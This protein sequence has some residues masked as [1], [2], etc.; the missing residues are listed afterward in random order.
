MLNTI[1]NLEKSYIFQ[2]FQPFLSR[3]LI[4]DLRKIRNSNKEI[5][6]KKIIKESKNNSWIIGVIDIGS[7][8]YT[9]G[10]SDIDLIIVVKKNIPTYDL[11]S[12]INKLFYNKYL[13]H[14]PPYLLIIY[15]E[16]FQLFAKYY[17]IV[18]LTNSFTWNKPSANKIL[19]D[20]CGI[21]YFVNRI[22]VPKICKII[23]LIETQAYSYIVQNENLRKQNIGLR[24]FL[25]RIKS[26]INRLSLL[27]EVTSINISS[28]TINILS[29]RYQ[30]ILNKCL[31]K[32]ILK[33][34]H[35]LN[36]KIW[37]L[38]NKI[39]SM[40][41]YYINLCFNQYFRNLSVKQ[42]NIS[43]FIMNTT[44][45]PIFFITNLIDINNLI[46]S[47]LINLCNY[48]IFD[49][50]FYEYL[51]YMKVGNKKKYLVEKELEIR[52]K[53]VYEWNNWL[54]KKGIQI[55]AKPVII[56]LINHEKEKTFLQKILNQVLIKLV[57]FQ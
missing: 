46:I 23:S 4:Y 21:K 27:N 43:S 6:I 34:D 39:I 25:K 29:E 33:T 8:N 41:K 30:M 36:K 7:K 2:I 40:E 20:K 13:F 32:N 54:V 37:E 26:R 45:G 55:Y 1:L 57:R 52:R 18:N 17:V 44:Y 28:E 51:E 16:L 56:E 3:K 49:S 31:N 9:Q 53:V 22:K 38:H 12:Y 24:I 19:V 35:K 10:I 42:N 47:K 48:S 50:T 15:E 14:N 11:K 5:I